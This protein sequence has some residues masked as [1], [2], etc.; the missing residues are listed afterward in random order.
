M[1]GDGH[2]G[3]THRTTRQDMCDTP[4]EK[5][6]TP[7][8]ELEPCRRW[9]R[10]MAALAVFLTVLGSAANNIGKVLQKEATKDLPQLSLSKAVMRRCVR[11]APVPRLCSRLRRVRPRRSI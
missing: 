2:T 10:S 11:A 6:F 1:G 8:K 9:T 5:D 7:E 3:V 4:P